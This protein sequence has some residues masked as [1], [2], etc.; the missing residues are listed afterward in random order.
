MNKGGIFH[1]FGHSGKPTLPYHIGA[2]IAVT[3]WGAAF[4]NTKV[5]LSHGLNPVE[6]YVYRFIIAYLCVLVLCPKP[7]FCHKISD[8]FKFLLCGLCGG[9]IYFIAEN[10]AVNYTMVSNVSLIV[11]TSP[12]LTAII[13]GVMYK[14]ERPTKGFMM[15]SAIAFMGVGCVIFNSSF[16]VKLKPFGDM[17]ALLSALCWAVYSVVLRPLNATYSVWFV[18]RKTFFYGLVTSLPFL[19]LEPHLASPALLMEPAVWG[20]LLFLGLFASLISYLLWSQAVK[21]LGV[22]T[23]GNYLYVSPIV[24]LLLSKF[25]LGENISWIGYAGCALI[26][27]GLVASEKLGGSRGEG[28]MR[29]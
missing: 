18:T 26:I 7:L 3:A 28:A 25:Y 22:M 20:N 6:I 24:T 21:G 11:S 10:T 19:A 5:L 4:I 16:V 8:E 27:L 14:S 2:A 23:S 1:R 29:H 13:I 17:L 9:S 12:L 15:G